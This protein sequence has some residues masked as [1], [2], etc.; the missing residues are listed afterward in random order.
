MTVKE[1]INKLSEF[2]SEIEVV[3]TQ[4][5]TIRPMNALTLG[6]N[7]EGSFFTL[8]ELKNDYH[9]DDPALHEELT[10]YKENA[11]MLGEY[12]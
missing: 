9:P 5:N 3:S 2:P 4:F 7:F 8:D 11:L 10:C 12:K 6:C 1:L